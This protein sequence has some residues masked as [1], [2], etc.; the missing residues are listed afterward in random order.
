MQADSFNA[1]RIRTVVVAVVSSNLQLANAP[2][3]VYLDSRESELP[4]ASVVNVSQLVTIDKSMLTEFVSTLS[5][6]TM[7]P[8]DEGLALV[9]DL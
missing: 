2:G 4:K 8:I 6:R 1:S 9:L 5:K 3:N 7:R